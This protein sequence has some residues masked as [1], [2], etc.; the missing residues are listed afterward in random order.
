M[1]TIA[2]IEPSTATGEAADLLEQVRKTL[3]LTPNM[4]KVEPHELEKARNGYSDD[5]HT[6]AL[7]M[8]SDTI[9]RGRGQVSDAALPTAR[10]AGV[11][12]AEIGEVVGHLAL[13]VLTNYFNILADVEND[14]PVIAAAQPAAGRPAAKARS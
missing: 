14:W 8:L 6:K 3:G 12:D 10:A 9:A 7:L 13:N 5:E 1:S 4:T 2:P 11:T